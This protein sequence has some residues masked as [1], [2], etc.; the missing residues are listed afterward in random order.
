MVSIYL[1]NCGILIKN[2]ESP[3]QSEVSNNNVQINHIDMR[4]N[5]ERG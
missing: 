4:E 5:L 1:L 2:T 3:M